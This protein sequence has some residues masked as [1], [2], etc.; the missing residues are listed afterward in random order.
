LT[1]P[2]GPQNPEQPQWQPG[3]WGAPPSGYQ[4]SPPGSQPPP[5]YGSPPGSPQG[6]FIPTGPRPPRKRSAARIGCL[7]VLGLFA[8]IVIIVAIASAV[9]GNK[10]SGN[11]AGSSNSSGSSQS[12]AAVVQ[13]SA[14]A[15]VQSSAPPPPQY[16]ASQQ[17]AI[18]AAESYLSEG[19]G[20]SKV[21]LIG[22]LDSS[23]GN[24]FS[25]ADALFAVNHVTVNWDQQAIDSAKSYLTSGQGFS[26]NGLLQQLT[27]QAGEGFS[28]SEATFALNHITVNWD[29]QAAI[30]AKGYMSS[31]EGF[32]CSGLLQQ[33]TSSSGEGFTQQQAEYGVKSVGLGSC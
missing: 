13:S 3:G 1:Q 14:P 8:L 16:T 12:P 29:Q 24:G 28:M 30:S 5:G 10:G 9:G 22:Q 2:P 7:S 15:A 25:Y 19:Q 26:Y 32:S 31:G 20:F 11:N 18:Q 21:G 23:A 33:L 6:G 17:Q 27:S 4:Q